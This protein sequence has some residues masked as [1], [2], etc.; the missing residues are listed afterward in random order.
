MNL[1]AKKDAQEGFESAVL[2]RT[3]HLPSPTLKLR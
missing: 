1:K 2:V 3:R